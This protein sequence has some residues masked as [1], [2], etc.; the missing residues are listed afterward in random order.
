MSHFVEIKT[1][2][3]DMQAL[4]AACAKL[5]IQVVQTKQVIGYGEAKETVEFALHFPGQTYRAGVRQGK[6]VYDPYF[7]PEREVHRFLDQYNA[8][9]IR[10]T[11]PR[12]E[13]HE[14]EIQGGGL[15]LYVRV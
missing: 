12:A 8:Q 1:E 7:L 3:R 2:L 13:I 14:E 9:V 10:R 6:L 4:R 15:K 5:N 11:Y